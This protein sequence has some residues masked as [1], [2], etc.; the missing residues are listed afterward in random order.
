MSQSLVL[1]L[2]HIIFSTKNRMPFFQSTELRSEAEI[3]MAFAF[4]ILLELVLR[5]LTKSAR[6]IFL[7]SP[8]RIWT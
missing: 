8:Q 5:F 3:V 2:V 4:T 6:E 7:E 1:V